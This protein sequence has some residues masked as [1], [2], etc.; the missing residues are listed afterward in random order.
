MTIKTEMELL[1]IEI[2]KLDVF[3]EDHQER[4]EELIF[5]R[6][7]GEFNSQN[8]LDAYAAWVEVLTDD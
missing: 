4:L 1:E 5:Y 3:N 6:N 8:A 7:Y 2:S